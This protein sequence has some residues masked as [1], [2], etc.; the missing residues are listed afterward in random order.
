MKK[1]FAV[2]LVLALLVPM[3]TAFA[4]DEPVVVTFSAGNFAK[5]A[6]IDDFEAKH[7]NIKI[8]VD[9]YAGSNGSG[10]L[11]NQVLHNE[12]SD[13]YMTTRFEDK[14]EAIAQNLVDLSTY[15]FVNEIS[16]SLLADVNQDG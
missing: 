9:A 14:K 8:D 1:V 12:Q 4:A 6:A 7:P 13:I 11:T 15:D 5:W 2:L 10:F 3:G 16:S